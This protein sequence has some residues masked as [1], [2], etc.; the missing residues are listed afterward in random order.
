[1]SDTD[2]I[3]DAIHTKFGKCVTHAISTPNAR[4][5]F[6]RLPFN[7]SAT[8]QRI[9]FDGAERFH[10]AS[11]E[12]GDGDIVMIGGRLTEDDHYSIYKT[13]NQTG[14]DARAL[15][16]FELLVNHSPAHPVKELE[17]WFQ[18]VRRLE[19]E[20]ITISSDGSLVR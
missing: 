19:S 14:C 7:I 20:G 8:D 12:Y 18:A 6:G 16:P 17:S 10:M 11:I 1:M 2:S 9:T 4:L 15:I 5:L 13:A 3:F